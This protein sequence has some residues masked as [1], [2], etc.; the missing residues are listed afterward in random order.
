MALEV[1][2]FGE[3]TNG[4]HSPSRVRCCGSCRCTHCPASP[5]LPSTLF[6]SGVLFRSS[7]GR[8]SGDAVPIYLGERHAGHDSVDD[9]A[10]PSS[11]RPVSG[12]DLYND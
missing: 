11:F 3:G 1:I 8:V 9:P 10:H 6:Y 2:G 12:W 7:V 5:V 4:F